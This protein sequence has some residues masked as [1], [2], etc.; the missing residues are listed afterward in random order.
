VPDGC[1]GG[2]GS[3]TGGG[4]EG[5]DALRRLE[6]S[7]IKS[8]LPAVN[9]ALNAATVLLVLVFIRRG[10]GGPRRCMLGAFATC[11]FLV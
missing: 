1:N 5:R 3:R 9:A 2:G 10:G 11:V 4:G 6:R 7:R 8:D